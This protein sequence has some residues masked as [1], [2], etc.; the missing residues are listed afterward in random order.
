[1]AGIV[2]HDTRTPWGAAARVFEVWIAWLRN[3]PPGLA[4]IKCG[5]V[6]TGLAISAW[7]AT[8]SVSFDGKEFGLR[9]S[10]EGDL[11]MPLLVSAFAAGLGLMAAGSWWCWWDVRLA[12]RRR[13]IV[14][15]VRGL[16]DWG[17]SPLAD[18]MPR[19]LKGQRVP[20]LIDLRQ[21]ADGVVL[22]PRL[23]L[24]K[25]A[26]LP[27][28]LTQLQ[29]GAGRSAATMV[30]GG[31]AS[32]P[33]TFLTGML[34][35]DE[36]PVVVMD[37]DRHAKRWR[38]LDAL[39]D[40][41]RFEETG[42]NAIVHGAREVALAVSVSY[43]VG[44]DAVRRKVPSIPLVQLELTGG[45]ADSH[46]S[47]DKQASLGEQFFRTAAALGSLGVRRIHLFLAAPNSVVFRFG[48]LYDRRNLPDVV[49]YQYEQRAEPPYPW[50]VRMPAS[51]E[52]R[53]EVEA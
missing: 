43:R 44:V 22:K 2:S 36:G 19:E 12:S 9:L 17:G 23:A 41:T 25:L 33:F 11:P 14:V 40:G 20:V 47:E 26:G 13:V 16:R 37:W 38:Q 24:E 31:L 49:V 3:R 46:W 35:D 52:T 32:V 51:G 48:Q 34:V 4:L 45:T 42:L 30:Y 29:G 8:V 15:E 27:V 28:Q 21:G 7:A 5:V 39:D 53:G 6:V 50:G 1:M 18:G 10:G